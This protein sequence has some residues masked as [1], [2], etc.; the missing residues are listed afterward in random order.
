M[1]LNTGPSVNDRLITLAMNYLHT[2]DP[3][4]DC[5]DPGTAEKASE[6]SQHRANQC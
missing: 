5:I 6:S 2:L 3:E 1:P 4:Y